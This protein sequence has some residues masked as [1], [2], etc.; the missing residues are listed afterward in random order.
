[1]RTLLLFGLFAACRP[2]APTAEQLAEIDR[3]FAAAHD[4]DD[5]DDRALSLALRNVAA[6]REFPNRGACTVRFTTGHSSLRVVD[7]VA[8]HRAQNA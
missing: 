3:I 7:G 5:D 4:D 6:P 8:D 2:S 1:M